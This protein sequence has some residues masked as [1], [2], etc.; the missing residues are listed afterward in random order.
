VPASDRASGVQRRYFN[1]RGWAVLA[2]VDAV[3]KARGASISQIA[4]AWQLSKP[5]VTSPII[6]PRTLEQFE[7]NLGA[8]GMRLT[9]EEMQQ[10]ND[11][12]AD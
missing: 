1:D 12:S 4:L 2:A 5:V 7:D 10:L 6:G 9:T 8:A 3:A 11:A